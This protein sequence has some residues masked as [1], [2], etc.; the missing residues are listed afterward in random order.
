MIT[1]SPERLATH[2]PEEIGDPYFSSP[3]YGIQAFM[4]WRPDIARRDL[5]RVQDL[6]FGWVKQ[7]FA[8]RDIET[9]E[10]DKYDC[11]L[12]TR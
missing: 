4:W 11:I 8:W 10:K 12:V 6:G 5:N 9:L 3:E 2:G 7:S 1:P